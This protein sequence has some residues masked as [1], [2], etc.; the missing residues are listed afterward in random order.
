MTKTP[1]PAPV[2]LAAAILESAIEDVED[3]R[4]SLLRASLDTTELLE[5]LDN[6]LAILDSQLEAT[7][8]DEDDWTY[9][10]ERD[11]EL[12]QLGGGR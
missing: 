4:S 3:V 12:R 2:T 11:A 7:P 5:C 8:A 10:A 1:T 9:E 6:A